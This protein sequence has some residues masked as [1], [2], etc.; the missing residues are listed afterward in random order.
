L[1]QA[2]ARAEASCRSATRISVLSRPTPLLARGFSLAWIL[3]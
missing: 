3:L 1:H 2:G